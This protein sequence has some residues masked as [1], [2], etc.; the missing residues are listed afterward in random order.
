MF[1]VFICGGVES[2]DYAVEGFARFDRKA[3]RGLLINGLALAKELFGLLACT[4]QRPIF[5]RRFDSLPTKFE[6]G[7]QPNT[8]ATVLVYQS[9]IGFRDPGAAAE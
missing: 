5:S 7:I 8:H 1:F 3:N 9:T 6:R 2:G 4:A